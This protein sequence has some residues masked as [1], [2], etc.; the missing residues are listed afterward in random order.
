MKKS[1]IA[2]G[3]PALLALFAIQ[4]H[5]QQ[6]VVEA[7][8]GSGNVIYGHNTGTQSA[9]GVGVYGES[10]PQPNYG[11]GVSGVGGWIGVRGQAIT[12]GTGT[13]YG[14]NFY[15]TN[16]ANQNYGLYAGAYG[17][18]NGANQNYGVYAN[19]YGPANSTNFGIY[20]SAGGDPS[21][22]NYAGYFVGDV[23]VSGTITSASDAR[24]KTD[25]RSL[26][27]A[28]AR[29]KGLRPSTYLFDDSR[30]KMRGLPKTRQ[31][32]LLAEDVKAVAP[33]LVLD[34]PVVDTPSVRG[35]KA[36]TQ[37]VQTVN[38]IGLIPVLVGAIKE[39]QAQIEALKAA[40]AT[41]K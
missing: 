32:G 24:L 14:G 18:A 21:S 29:I 11:I 40:L 30:I 8:P 2:L 38:Y 27:G 10:T 12:S 7:D 33:E 34:V 25:I 13:R 41:R 9:D 20:A 39:Q 3:V 1:S 5:A 37:T 22:T 31:I 19:A 23:F 16:G 6:L 17:P 36:P 28:L 15:A 4:A 35:S 26:D